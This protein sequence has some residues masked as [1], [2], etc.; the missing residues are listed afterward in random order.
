M[1]IA[2][3]RQITTRFR[4]VVVSNCLAVM[5]PGRILRRT[6]LL[7]GR[8]GQQRAD[9]WEA[10]DDATVR[11]KMR[12]ATGAWRHALAEL[13]RL[14]ERDGPPTQAPRSNVLDARGR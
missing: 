13:A 7:A 4:V 6:A 3:K 1:P 2:D 12:A 9:L 10:R 14:L 8:I 11:R 5:Q